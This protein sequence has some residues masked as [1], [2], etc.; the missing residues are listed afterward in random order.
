MPRFSR[1]TIKQSEGQ[2]HFSLLNVRI[3]AKQ[4]HP[5][6][7]KGLAQYVYKGKALQGLPDNFRI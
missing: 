5:P 2:P 6:E 7:N 3:E 1:L 4:D